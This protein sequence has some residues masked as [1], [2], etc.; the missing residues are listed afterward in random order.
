VLIFSL[1]D[2]VCG[3]SD[4]LLEE[5]RGWDRLLDDCDWGFVEE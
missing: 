4:E 3:L 5:W 2:T 1:A